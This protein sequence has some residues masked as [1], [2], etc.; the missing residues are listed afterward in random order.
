MTRLSLGLLAALSL[1]WLAACGDS[2]IGGLPASTAT[3]TLGSTRIPTVEATPTRS[4]SPAGTP[5]NSPTPDS[6]PTPDGGASILP[7]IVE[8][9]RVVFRSQGGETCCVAV[10][11]AL[12]PT[13]PQPGQPTLVLTDLPI[14]PATVTISGYVQDFAPAPGDATATCNTLNTSGVASCDLSRQASPAYESAPNPVTIVPGVRVNLG[15]VEVVALPF[16]LD[17][18][19]PQNGEAQSPVAIRFTV[20]DAETGIAGS[21]IA[22]D[23]TFDAALPP[24]TERVPLTLAACADATGEPCSPQG[25]FGVSGFKAQAMVTYPSSLPRGGVTVRIMAENLAT[26]PR[27]LDFTY[28][29]TAAPQP[30]ATA[31]ATPTVTPTFTLTPTL[32]SAPTL[33]PTPSPTATASHTATLV[34]TPTMSAT[35]TRTAT[36]TPTRTARPTSVDTVTPTVTPTRT[37]TETPTPTPTTLC[38]ATPRSGCRNAPSANLRLKVAPGGDTLD[39]RWLSGSAP[40]GEFGNPTSTTLYALCIYD[41]VQRVPRLVFTAQVEPGG[42]CGRSPCWSTV[43][44]PPIGYRF[45]DSDGLQGGMEKLLLRD[46]SAARDSIIAQ[47][48]GV[49]LKLPLPVGVDQFF[50]QQDDVVVQLVNDVAGCWESTFRPGDVSANSSA[51]YDA[52]R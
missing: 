32:T 20:V 9:G 51:L 33:S 40:L 23:V 8:T 22:L 24:V 49:H 28:R 46:R 14:G 10:D 30:T 15:D 25:S 11:P 37:F 44:S 52:A 19:P 13:N 17:Y 1:G 27:S 26:P 38:D 6:S 5:A 45:L 3:P 34:P 29:F 42:F 4:G 31:S 43:G 16:L 36:P 48:G 12:L 47:G 2:S 39:W 41:S 50:A 21:S 7:A 18:A 35:R